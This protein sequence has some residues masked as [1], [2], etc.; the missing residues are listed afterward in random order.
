MKILIIDKTDEWFKNKLINNNCIITEKLYE[1]K[2]KILENFDFEGLI[3]RSRFNIDS[4]FIKK[5]KGLKFIARY[6]SGIEHIDVN[7]AKK[8]N[9]T[10][11]NCPEGN[12][13][14][15]A[16]HTIGLILCLFNK[17]NVSNNQ[18]KKGVWDREGNRGLE[19]M[20]KTIGIIGYGNTGQSLCEKLK[21]FNCN[22][23]VYDKY[24][25]NYGDDFIKEV[26]MDE[27]FNNS[28]ILSL[29]IPLN[30]ETINMI[31][32]SFL[33]KFKK[34][35]FVINTS[36]GKIINTNDLINLLIEQKVLGACLDVLE[37]EE[38]SFEKINNKNDNMIFLNKSDNVLL[39]P[40]IAG[41]T[42]ESR[43]KLSKILAKKILDF[44]KSIK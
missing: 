16:E 23:I 32:R 9:I 13:D 26:S 6:G 4:E 37:Y 5:A 21:G 12:K 10:C 7:A 22:I 44:I 30:N 1:S 27:I 41:L 43:K 25:E 24:K 28:D 3:L 40:H 18:I 34:P 35:I 29:H 2:E 38:M 11:I 8:N 19:L 39:T 36:R 31:N 15:V 20:H 17:I 14:A 33:N 42:F